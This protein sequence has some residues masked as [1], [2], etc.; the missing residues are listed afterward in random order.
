[1]ILFFAAFDEAASLRARLL[2]FLGNISME[3]FLIHQLVLRYAKLWFDTAAQP[4]L[5][6]IACYLIAWLL[7][8]AAHRAFAGGRKRSEARS[9]RRNAP[10]ER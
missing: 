8:Y 10:S 1:M 4:L 6:A 2:V 5:F 7:A 9:L 3:F